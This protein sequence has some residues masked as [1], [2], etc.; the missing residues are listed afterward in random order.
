MKDG[1][2]RASEGKETREANRAEGIE[3]NAYDKEW[4]IG[5]ASCKAKLGNMPV[6]TH[7]EQSKRW[8]ID[9]VTSLVLGSLV[10]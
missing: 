5:T 2:P 9:G 4:E 3:R 8:V 7:K 1:G 10:S 6:A